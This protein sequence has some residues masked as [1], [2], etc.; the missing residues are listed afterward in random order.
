MLSRGCRVLT[1]SDCR[2]TCRPFRAEP[3]SGLCLTGVPLTPLLGVPSTRELG[4]PYVSGELISKSRGTATKIK[5][6]VYGAI[7]IVCLFSKCKSKRFWRLFYVKGTRNAFSILYALTWTI[8]ALIYS[9]FHEETYAG[10]MLRHNINYVIKG[11]NMISCVIKHMWFS[12]QKPTWRTYLRRAGK[13]GILSRR[14]SQVHSGWGGHRL[15]LSS[16]SG[17]LGST[18]LRGR[19][20]G[21]LAS[22]LRHTKQ[23]LMLWFSLSEVIS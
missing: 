18:S 23:T 20:P 6:K 19:W 21:I 10:R 16:A 22:G 11:A 15:Q 1:P 7:L 12:L 2:S 4:V 13:Q 5:C 17:I 9:S 3:R 8:S 14:A